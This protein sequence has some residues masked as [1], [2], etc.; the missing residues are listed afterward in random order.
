VREWAA[1]NLARGMSGS[2]AGPMRRRGRR[3]RRWSASGDHRY[4][5]RASF[6]KENGAEN[7]SHH[8]ARRAARALFRPANCE[9]IDAG[10]RLTRFPSRHVRGAAI[11]L[12][13][14]SRRLG[15]IGVNCIRRAK[16]RRPTL[17][18]RTTGGD[19][20]R[21]RRL[22][23][24]GNALVGKESGSAASRAA[25]CFGAGQRGVAHAES[26]AVV[27]GERAS[28]S[29]YGGRDALTR[30][31]LNP[32]GHQI[33]RLRSRSGHGSVSQAVLRLVVLVGL[34]AVRY[35]Q[36]Q[37]A[38]FQ[39]RR[40]PGDT[41]HEVGLALIVARVFQR[42]CEQDPVQFAGGDGAEPRL[43]PRA[44]GAG[45]LSGIPA[46]LGYEVARG[47]GRR[48]RI[49]AQVAGTVDLRSVRQAGPADDP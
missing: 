11:R 33:Y 31:T 41:Q 28:E 34:D 37:L 20:R 46:W 13:R 44:D 29:D 12:A 5:I 4:L 16:R 22:S 2:L 43:V 25:R 49:W 18:T 1:P 14:S 21:G 19:A 38:E 15:A 24:D 8:G 36:P 23:V 6:G 26:S 42:T 45:E 47:R 40:L 35:M 27:A 17:R 3:G 39:P 30:V 10:T 9:F 32:A 48:V 7:L